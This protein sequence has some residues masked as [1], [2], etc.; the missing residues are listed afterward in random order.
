MCTQKINWLFC[1]GLIEKSILDFEQGKE[2]INFYV[3][4]NHLEIF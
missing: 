4:R 1:L 3:I 2:V